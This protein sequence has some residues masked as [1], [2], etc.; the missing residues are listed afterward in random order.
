MAVRTSPPQA[1]VVG[2][3]VSMATDTRPWCIFKARRCVARVASYCGVQPQEGK[4]RDVMI[5]CHLMAPA[6]FLV[7]V[8]AVSAQLP[9]V[10]VVL[11]MAGNAGRF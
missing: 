2:I 10:S 8:L 4:A 7:T 6:L 5:K 9:F 11:A 1:T 3:L